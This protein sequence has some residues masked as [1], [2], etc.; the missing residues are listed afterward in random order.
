MGIPISTVYERST[1]EPSIWYRISEMIA[2]GEGQVFWSRISR[3]LGCTI[4]Y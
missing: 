4:P 1:Q 2:P 3:F